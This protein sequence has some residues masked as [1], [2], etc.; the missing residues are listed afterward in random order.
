MTA[1]I[2][3][4]HPPHYEALRAS[5]AAARAVISGMVAIVVIEPGHD[6]PNAGEDFAFEA[7][8]NRGQHLNGHE[9]VDGVIDALAAVVS[10]TSATQ[11]VKLDSDILLDSGDWIRDGQI[12][13][14]RTRYHF[15]PLYSAPSC[16]I[17]DIACIHRL[18]PFNS[19]HESNA[20]GQAL[21]SYAH[22]TET[23]IS[24]RLCK[25]EDLPCKFQPYQ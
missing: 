14:F 9:A 17:R 16:A 20:I 13:T 15:F 4:S 8:F 5:I 22:Y 21:S 2:W 6:T 3:F 25:Q 11:I 24:E 23:L 7:G 10:K 12:S 19:V 1:A 18:R